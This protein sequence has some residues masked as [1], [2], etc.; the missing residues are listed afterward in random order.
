MIW[1]IF[2]H[3]GYKAVSENGK[4]GVINRQ[5]RYVVP[6]VWDG[7][8]GDGQNGIYTVIRVEQGGRYKFKFGFVNVHNQVI[9]A[10]KYDHVYEFF[11]GYANVKDIAGKYGLIDTQGNWVIQ[12]QYSSPLN[13]ADN[14]L[15]PFAQNGLYGYMDFNENIVIE[16]QF[17]MAYTFFDGFGVIQKNGYTGIIN[18]KGEF[19]INPSLGYQEVARTEDNKYLIGQ[20]QNMSVV[21]KIIYQ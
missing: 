4:W 16:P 18:T 7:I 8:E 12:P 21:Y 5:G 20:K 9:L 10:P 1:A 17:T 15:I 19:L 2:F 6:P 14:G 3:D 13:Y 11:N